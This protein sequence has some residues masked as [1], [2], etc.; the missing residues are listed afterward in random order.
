MIGRLDK[1]ELDLGFAIFIRGIA[2]TQLL[3]TEQRVEGAHKVRVWKNG[4]RPPIPTPFTTQINLRLR[5]GL[6][7]SAYRDGITNRFYFSKNDLSSPIVAMEIAI[8]S[9][10]KPT[11]P[12]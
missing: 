7:W 8:R 9:E 3:S 12:N 11:S 5:E 1:R 2:A 10:E 4:R 6:F